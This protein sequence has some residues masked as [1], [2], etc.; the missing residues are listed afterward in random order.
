[1]KKRLYLVCFALIAIIFTF[2]LAPTANSATQGLNKTLNITG[3]GFDKQRYSGTLQVVSRKLVSPS[4]DIEGVTLTWNVG[5]TIYKGIGIST[6]R[7]L[8]ATWGGSS[9]SLV[10]YAVEGNQLKGLWTVA[11]QSKL[12]T[13]LANLSSGSGIAGSYRV[14]GTNLNGSPYKGSLDITQQG[15]VY[16]FSW[17]TGIKYEGIGIKT[18]DLISVAYGANGKDIC[19]V[20]QYEITD[21]GLKGGKWGMYGENALGTEQGTLR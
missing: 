19:G 1:M 9:C 6:D 4:A 17:N 7:I 14:T 13:E 8:T 15:P 5:G 2:Q 18:Q 16:Q 21:T 20:V 3:T 11:G 10:V 12:G